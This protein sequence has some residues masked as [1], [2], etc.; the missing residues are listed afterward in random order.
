MKMLFAA[1][2]DC[3]WG[4]SC[5]SWRQPI[6]SATSPPTATPPWSW[7]PAP[8]ASCTRSTWRSCRPI[9]S[10]RRS[11]RT[12]TERPTRRSVARTRLARRKAIASN[13]DLSLDG[14]R[15][16]LTPL[17]TALEISPGAGGL[18][19]LRLD[20]TYEAMLPKLAGDLTFADRNF[21]GR[22]G[23]R[24]V[25]GAPSDGVKLTGSERAGARREPGAARLSRRH[26][27]GAAPRLR[28][29]HAPVGWRA[30][31]LGHAVADSGRAVAP[32]ASAIA[33]RPSSPIRRRSAAG[34]S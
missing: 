1:V 26:A 10:C 22:P 7:S 32:S 20:V 31:C 14:T 19:T 3:S 5:R 34:P 30:G 17:A 27:A 21:V 18:S 16:A 28:G 6:R 9:A 23:W 8:C 13:L 33:S 24:E 11:T 12:V 15:L 4:C 2:W 29:A 25:V